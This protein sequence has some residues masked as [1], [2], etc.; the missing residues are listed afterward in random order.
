VAYPELLLHL[1]YVETNVMPVHSKNILAGQDFDAVGKLL[2]AQG[3]KALKPAGTYINVFIAS[4]SG[5]E[6]ENQLFLNELIEVGR[7]K[8]ATHRVYPLVQIVD[9]HIILSK[10]TPGARWL[11][12][13]RVRRNKTMDTKI[14]L[15]ATWVVVTLIYLHGD[16]FRICSGDLAK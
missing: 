1:T 5:D 2:P 16:V 8:P 12:Q 9:A 13:S 15:S 3:K 14:I 6:V 10:V 7:L 4:D 11:S